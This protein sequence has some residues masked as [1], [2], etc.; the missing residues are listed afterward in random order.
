ASAG[1]VPGPATP[2]PPGLPD[3]DTTL[4]ELAG[5][6]WVLDP[7]GAPSLVPL[8]A[9]AATG[10][11]PVLESMQVFDY[12]DTAVHQAASVVRF[13]P[14]DGRHRSREP[15]RARR[16][17]LPEDVD[18]RQVRP[19]RGGAGDDRRPIPPGRV[20]PPVRGEAAPER[21]A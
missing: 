5:D 10:F 12:V 19:R 7:T 15:G 20:R 14:E 9:G 6:R 3:R 13:N 4:S 2:P 21:L 11:D 18:L 8:P 1:S 16:G 17:Q